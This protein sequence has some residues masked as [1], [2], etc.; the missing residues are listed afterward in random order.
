MLKQTEKTLNGNI[1]K[2]KSA[3]LNMDSGAN[4]AGESADNQLLHVDIHIDEDVP[5]RG[6]LELLGRLR[7]HWKAEEIQMKASEG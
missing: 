5:R 3:V 2:T 7:P 6:V 1:A 4:G